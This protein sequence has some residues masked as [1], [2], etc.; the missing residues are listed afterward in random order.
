[1]VTWKGCGNK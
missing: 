1:M